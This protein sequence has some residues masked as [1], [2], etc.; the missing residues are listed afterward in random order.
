[1]KEA[2]RELLAD[3]SWE[4]TPKAAAQLPELHALAPNSRLFI[5]CLPKGSLEETLNVAE[6]AA[7]LGFHPIPHISARNIYDREQLHQVLRRLAQLSGEGL[8][9]A[10]AGAGAH[11]EFHD[12]Y[13]LM[14]SGLLENAGLRRLWFAGHCEGH[15]QVGASDLARAEQYKWAWCQNQGL[16]AG[17][18]SQFCFHG[19]ALI[20][21][22]EGL[23]RR[24]LAFPLTVGVA[25]LAT[26]AKLLR[27][28][29]ACGVGDS[30]QYLRR[31]GWGLFNLLLRQKPDRFIYQ[32]ARA[33]LEG[34]LPHFRR[35]HFF[36]FG[37]YRE[38]L[39]WAA[40]VRDGRFRLRGEGFKVL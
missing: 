15:P 40:K 26:I 14:H 20:A 39:L 16:A 12:C 23:E 33:R 17:L 19:E 1:M 35:L 10:G 11:G 7:D 9:L 34:R 30:L 8:F 38:T 13:D 24:Q 5:T 37:G 3:F 27:H 21:W 25:G 2:I 31:S 6:G 22:A 18:V 29:Q 32:L 36:P 4:I 28:G